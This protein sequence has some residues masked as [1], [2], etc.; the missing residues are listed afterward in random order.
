MSKAAKRIALFM[1]TV[2]LMLVIVS[3]GYTTSREMVSR[4]AIDRRYSAAYDSVETEY[5]YK[6][7]FLE[8]AFVL[9]PDIKTVHHEEVYEV[10]YRTTYDDGSTRDRWETVG[11]E[12]WEAAGTCITAGV[13][14]NAIDRR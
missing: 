10:L 12:E 14:T 6:Y 8:R 1:L 13:T 7:N 9:V 3:C 2:V 11:K 5:Q 4:E